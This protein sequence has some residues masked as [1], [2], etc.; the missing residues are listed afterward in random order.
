MF[1][2]VSEMQIK[3]TVRC[4]FHAFDGYDQTDRELTGDDED[5]EKRKPSSPAGVNVKSALFPHLGFCHSLHPRGLF[6]INKIAGAGEDPALGAQ[7]LWFHSHLA[8]VWDVILVIWPL[9]LYFSLLAGS[10]IEPRAA[11]VSFPHPALP[12]RLPN[13]W[14]PL[15]SPQCTSLHFLKVSP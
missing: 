5:V 11:H 6:P 9:W 7:E 12:H 13:P 2:I 15:P 14:L 3:S 8:L 4:H 10:G 1:R